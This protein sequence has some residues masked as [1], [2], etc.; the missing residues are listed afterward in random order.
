[1]HKLILFILL[2]FGIIFCPSLFSKE[3]T[4]S[5]E[6]Y[7]INVLKYHPKANIAE[8]NLKLSEAQWKSAN[9]Q[10]DPFLKAEYDDKYFDQ[11]Q[12]FQ[13]LR[14][15]IELPS[16]LGLTFNAGYD[17]TRGIFLNPENNTPNDGLGYIGVEANL[18]QG[19][20]IDERRTAVN[21]AEIFEDFANNRRQIEINDLIIDASI[22]Y[23]QWQST[24]E[25]QLI[26]QESVDLARQYFENNLQSYLFGD[27]PAVDTLE[28]FLALQDQLI[29]LQS[30]NVELVKARN[31]LNN[32]TWEN[33]ENITLNDGI[34]PNRIELLSSSIISEDTITYV[35]NPLLEEKRNKINL[36][37]AE[38]DLKSDKLKPKLKVK[39]NALTSELNNNIPTF[40][41]NNY[42]WGL[43]FSMPLLFRSERGELEMNEL[44]IKETELDLINYETSLKNKQKSNIETL[45]ILNDQLQ[46][47]KENVNRYKQLL[48]FEKEKFD[49]GESSVFLVNKRQ[50]KYIFSKLK[51][52]D[53]SIKYNIEVLYNLLLSDQIENYFR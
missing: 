36:L 47:V 11:K 35:G 52:I 24:H 30:N 43:S 12:Y 17:N 46:I 38:N 50:E 8:L 18:L 40:N 31:N 23:Y 9:G 15:S 4:L 2:T 25:Y 7:I 51:V 33:D 1:M 22:A 10:F 32:F 14:S 6:N 53:L 39:Y 48:E 27:K 41:I 3:D 28:S 26:I 49:I 16:Y 44:K 37:L 19:L 21:Q 20:L 42:K 34:N 5:F 45:E 29:M 13:V